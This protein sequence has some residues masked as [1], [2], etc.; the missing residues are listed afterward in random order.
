MRRSARIQTPHEQTRL[1]QFPPI[2]QLPS[3]VFWK[4]TFQLVTLD[5]L[6]IQKLE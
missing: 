6:V 2:P 3:Q 5:S 1:Q 4:S